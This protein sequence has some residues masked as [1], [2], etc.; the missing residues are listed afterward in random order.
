M[1]LYA[2][3]LACC[4]SVLSI[5]FPGLQKLIV[6]GI[7]LLIAFV[8]ILL[9]PHLLA[10]FANKG[11]RKLTLVDDGLLVSSGQRSGKIKW[12]SISHLVVSDNYFL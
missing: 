9:F 7:G 2:L 3:I 8:C 1:F 4:L 11:T 12:R 6:I 5:S 10:L